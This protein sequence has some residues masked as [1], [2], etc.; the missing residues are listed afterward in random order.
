MFLNKIIGCQRAHPVRGIGPVD[1]HEVEVESR[2]D[3]GSSIEASCQFSFRDPEPGGDLGLAPRFHPEVADDR[4]GLR[5]NE[6]C[7]CPS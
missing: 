7:Q 4:S 5:G 1:L 3:I 2:S 6:Y